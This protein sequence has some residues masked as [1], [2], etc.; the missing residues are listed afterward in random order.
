MEPGAATFVV[1]SDVEALRTAI[2]D[3]DV[4]VLAPR[5]GEW[6]RDVWPDARK[7]RWI[8]SLGAG[9]EKLPFDILRDSDVVVTNARGVYAGALAEWVIGAMLYFAKDFRRLTTAREWKPFHVERLEGAT[10][11]IVGY[12]NIGEAI[13]RRA[14]AFGMR[15]LTA[16]RSDPVDDLIAASDYVVLSTPLTPATHRLMNADRIARMKPSA[17]LVNISRGQVVDEAALIDALGAHRI[18]GA[19]LDVFETEPLPPDSPL[20]TLDNVLLSPHS[21]DRTTD[22]HERAIAVFRANLARFERGEPLENIVEKV[23]GY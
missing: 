2:R 1:V 15:I 5:Y 12:G 17:V 13:A 6:I 11:G 20:W 22:S 18:R 7:L 8:H 14:N 19:A 21:A 23:R 3:A 4:L 10:L 16:R 9:V